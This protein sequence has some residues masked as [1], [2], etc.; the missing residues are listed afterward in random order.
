MPR[1]PAPRRPG[2]SGRLFRAPGARPAHR[3]AARRGLSGA[4]ARAPRAGAPERA[5]GAAQRGLAFCQGRVCR[6]L[7]AVTEA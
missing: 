2:R 7:R 4:G 1:A 5:V 6:E 3:A